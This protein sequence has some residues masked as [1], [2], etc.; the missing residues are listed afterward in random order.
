[1]G[2]SRRV[3]RARRRGL[4][5]ACLLFLA[6]L[7]A[8]G[9]DEARRR[10]S[11]TA[12]EADHV[13]QARFVRSGGPVPPKLEQPGVLLVLAGSALPPDPHASAPE[14]VRA[15][16]RPF[17]LLFGALV[18]VSGA[19][20]ARRSGAAAGIAVTALLV[21]D[22]TLRGHGA[23]VKT[24]VPVAL[25]LVASAAA[26]DLGLSQARRPRALLLLCA[27]GASY[28]LALATKA[29]AAAFLPLFL[30]AALPGLLAR[31][32]R[33]GAGIAALLVPAA[34]V[35]LAVQ[36]FAFRSVPRESIRA[37]ATR[38][39]R[40]MPEPAPARERI[41]AS[42]PKGIAAWA[43]GADYLRRRGRPGKWLNYLNAEVRGGGFLLYYPVALL[44]KL[45]VGTLALCLGAPLAL[46]AAWGRA[47][48]LRRR[49][50]LRLA[51]G[52][53]VL[54]G[55]L[56]LSWI[57]LMSVAPINIGVRY[58]L[59]GAVLLVVSAAG[60]LAT[61]LRGTR[62]RVGVPAL[63]VLATAAEALA[64]RGREI[65]FGNLLAGGPS[66]LRRVLTDSNVEWGQEQERMFA[67][68][69]AGDLGR[70][71]VVAPY[72][73]AELARRA[74]VAWISRAEEAGDAVFVSTFAWDLAHALARWDEG[75]RYP[76][77]AY[78][79]SWMVPLVL[80]LEERASSVEPFGDG[81]LLL[82]L[83]PAPTG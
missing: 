24:D 72:V 5:L 15:A 49:R 22:P 13:A 51:R 26:L 48:P 44:V 17:P 61:A 68:A 31:R 59:P 56:G 67:R 37:A 39:F 70:V 10:F 54:P 77:I 27:S 3:S 18:L 63:L 79:R 1:M 64:F 55:F 42:A 11:P 30:A 71:A 23:L 66:G 80:G 6:A 19:W 16:R 83:R 65:S 29:S 9:A 45:P 36:A 76:W 32:R 57:A 35:L 50:L 81:Y 28:G 78:V 60:I 12:D 74:G 58:G 40:T 7:A 38:M 4:L 69:S 43:G 62:W 25:F 82:R 41:L 33:A 73:D 14:E 2:E 52:R 20:A 8:A 75:P 34:A 21:L 53:A 47:S 46:L